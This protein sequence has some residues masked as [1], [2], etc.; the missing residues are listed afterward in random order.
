MPKAVQLQEFHQK[1][2]HIVEFAGFDLPLWFKGIIAESRA[3]RNSVGLFDVS[4]MGRAIV[5]GKDSLSL[6]ETL[7]TNKVASLRKEQGQ[8][9][10][11]CNE[12]GGIK[13]DL[14]VFHLS[15]DEY[16]LVYNA[17]NRSK[18]FDWLLRHAK[19]Q[20]IELQD[21]SD[22]VAM[23]ALQGPD[24]TKVLGRITDGNVE[25]IPRFG[26]GWNEVGGTKS[27]ISR[28]GYTGEDGFEIFVWN[29]TLTNPDRARVVWEKLL[30]NGRPEGIEPCGLG[31]RDLLRLEAGL[32]L[33]GT[34]MDETINPY[35]ARL[36]FVVKLE[37]S[38]IGRDRL[39]IVKRNGP[40][41]VR[42]GLITSN[43]VIPRHGCEILQHG[44]KMGT[45]TS[46]SLSPIL[47]KGIAMG[48]VNAKEMSTESPFEI[49]IRDRRE[50]ALFAKPPFYDR[51][52]F[53]YARKN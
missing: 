4:H 51:N 40:E 15:D 17:G 19:D 46:G 2:G 28:T 13:D 50:G 36:G 27:L 47:N 32:C 53:G 35:E 10:L 16:F 30:E 33:Y 9:S 14:M 20:Q 7:T 29:S 18:N 5:R 26:C 45:V 38:F 24:S 31:A 12:A 37:K 43:R 3:V 41:K 44:H 49:R 11:L 48:Y 25:A 39:Q 21:V 34:D 42:I 52:R 6:L 1:H 8:Y 23:F 22:N